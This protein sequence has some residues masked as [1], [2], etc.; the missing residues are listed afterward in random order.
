[1][2]SVVDVYFEEREFALMLRFIFFIK[3]RI[4]NDFADDDDEAVNSFGSS[5]SCSLHLISSTSPDLIRY[6]CLDGVFSAKII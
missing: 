1:M 5:L 4:A 2:D 6:T 3:G